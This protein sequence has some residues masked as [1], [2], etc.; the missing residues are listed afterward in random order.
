MKTHYYL[1][2]AAL[3]LLGSLFLAGCEAPPP[4][5]VQ[6][7]Y[8]GVGQEHIANPR[9]LAATVAEALMCSLGGSAFIAIKIPGAEPELIDGADAM[10]RIPPEVLEG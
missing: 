6:L 10:P 7:G 5:A 2:A 3:S 4:E 8:R 9:T 1:R